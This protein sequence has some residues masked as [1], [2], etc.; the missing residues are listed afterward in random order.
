MLNWK[1]LRKISWHQSQE[2]ER[3]VSTRVVVELAW[4]GC[5]YFPLSKSRPL[6]TDRGKPR[7][8]QID[9]ICLPCPMIL[10]FVNDHLYIRT[11]GS[12]HRTSSF[13]NLQCGSTP[14]TK[15]LTDRHCPHWSPLFM[16]RS[17]PYTNPNVHDCS[18]QRVRLTGY[19][20]S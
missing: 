15:T 19:W 5:K 14:P 9:E 4:P 2:A 1:F 11:W 10:P 3:Y 8:V 13:L 16:C 6:Q 17:F 20:W 18:C 7:G 12:K